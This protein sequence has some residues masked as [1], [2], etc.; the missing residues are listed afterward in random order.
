MDGPELYLSLGHMSHFTRREIKVE[1]DVEETGESGALFLAQPDMAYQQLYAE[2]PH[3]GHIGHAHA[4][5]VGRYVGARAPPRQSDH[6]PRHDGGEA[7]LRGLKR[8]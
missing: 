5:W 2:V 4:L 1:A 3:R 8:L 6:V 7:G